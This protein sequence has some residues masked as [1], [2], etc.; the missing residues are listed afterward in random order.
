VTL[1]ID[2]PKADLLDLPL[3]SIIETESSG[4]EADDLEVSELEPSH[5]ELC[6][7]RCPLEPMPP[8][9]SQTDWFTQALLTDA[10]RHP[11]RNAW[12]DEDEETEDEP[13]DDE[14]T[15]DE[16]DEPDPFDDF[17]EDDFDDDFDDD[18]EEELDD[19]Y[20][21]EPKDDGLAPGTDDAEDVDPDLLADGPIDDA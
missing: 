14:V 20:E 18:F 7:I 5:Q 10:P 8:D 16:E 6:Q 21:I 11:V 13:V 2:S 19:E 3:G 12:D 1:L 9:E 15:P 17:D 4:F